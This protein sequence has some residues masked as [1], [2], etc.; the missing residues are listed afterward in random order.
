MPRALIWN[1]LILP[2]CFPPGLKRDCFSIFRLVSLLVSLVFLIQDGVAQELKGAEVQPT[3]RVLLMFS[4][5]RDL[6]GNAM[7][8]QAVRAEMLKGGTNQIEFFAENLDAGR[9]SDAGQYVVF[10]DYL[11]KKYAEKKLDLVI[12][13]MARDFGLVGELTAT[14][15]SNLPVVFVAVNELDLPPELAGRRVAG[16]VQHFDVEGTIKLIFHLQPTTRRLVVIGGVSKMDR[17]TLARIEAVDHSLDNIDFEYWTNRPIAEM[18]R[19]VALLP[20]DTVVLLSTVQRDV[21]GQQFYTS[22]VGQMLAASASAPIYT[23]SAGLI[24]SGVLGGDVVDFESLG[25][26]AGRLA[27]KAFTAEP[28]ARSEAIEVRK[29]GTPMFDWRALQRWG[30]KPN[31]LPANASIRYRPRSL[32]EEHRSLIL[33]ALLILLAQAATI[34]ALLAQRTRRRSAEQQIQQQRM[35]LA[36]VTRV[37]TLGQLASALTHELNQ[38]LGAILRNTEAAEM[39]LQHDQPDLKEVREIL[40]DIRKDDQRAGEVIGRM[41]A[42]LK[43]RNLDS[44]R[45]D[46]YELVEDTQAVARHDALARRVTLA[47][48]MPAHLPAVI[49]DRVHLQQVLLNLILNGMDAMSACS[50]DDRLLVVRARK[51]TEG[52]VEVSVSDRGAGLTPEATTRIFES[53]FT[54]KPQGLGMG[55]AISQTIIGAH[56]GKIRGENNSGRGATFTFTLPTVEA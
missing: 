19:D 52:S 11:E 14:V 27:L 45:L 47:V 3:K 46:L 35:E 56:G 41:R 28:V 55:L 31:R 30:I 38:P 8:E 42:L 23:L 40:A 24:G 9:F 13:F 1:R 44:V 48:E 53:F 29:N 21:S 49:G 16:I 10:K 22:Q 33:S 18:R 37:T 50:V 26:S 20:G 43:R 34:A 12:A 51:G 17:L 54:T 6:P 7:M 15:V 25:T 4:E 32:W 39:F 5:A 36:H 2:R